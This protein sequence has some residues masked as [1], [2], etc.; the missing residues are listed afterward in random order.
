MQWLPHLFMQVAPPVVM[1]VRRQSV[2]GAGVATLG[3]ATAGAGA[4]ARGSVVYVT[5]PAVDAETPAVMT[6]H[7]VHAVIK[8]HKKDM[9]RAVALTKILC[10]AQ[11]VID[12]QEA[13]LVCR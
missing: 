4:A 6:P 12:K 2:G 1:A 11:A 10:S 9:A 13:I 8:A 7:E 3:G 5:S